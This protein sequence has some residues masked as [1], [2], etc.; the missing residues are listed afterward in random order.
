MARVGDEVPL[1]LECR[2]EP[3]EHLVQRRP[4][5]LQLVPGGRNGETLAP[6]VRRDRRRPPAHRLDLPQREPG[7]AVSGEGG[8]EQRDRA[9]DQELVAEASERL[10]PVLASRADDQ[11]PASD[12]NREQPRRLVETRERSA[13]GVERASARLAKLRPAQQ[14]HRPQRPRRLE[15]ASPRVEKLRVALAPLDEA[16]AAV[17]RE[18]RVRLAYE[19]GEILCAELELAVERRLEVG[20][21]AEVE[22]EA[23]GGEHGRH[24]DR[25]RGGDT[26][27]DRQPAHVTSSRSR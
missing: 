1:A 18:G 8:Q 27:A 12:R 5:S 9:R 10:G 20:A 4:E 21:E 22:E 11:D 17:V 26:D 6:S 24:R 2:L 19:R 7:E 25:E 13:I 16:G 3:V 14:R 15:D 23:G